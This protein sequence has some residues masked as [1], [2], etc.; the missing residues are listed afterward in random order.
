MTS[1]TLISEM[2]IHTGG[3]STEVTQH[4]D[5]AKRDKAIREKQNDECSADTD[6]ESGGFPI[7]NKPRWWQ[8]SKVSRWLRSI[9]KNNKQ[10]F[11]IVFAVFSVLLVPRT[12]FLTPYSTWFALINAL[13]D[14]LG[15][16]IPDNGL[17][18][19]VQNWHRPGDI[20]TLSSWPKDFSRDVIPVPCHSH[21]DYSR[22]VPLFDALAAG[23]VSVE[24]D[25]WSRNGSDDLLIGHNERSLSS[26]RTLKSLYIEPLMAILKHQNQG[27]AAT[28]VAGVFET[29]PN[30]TLVLLLD[31]KT[32]DAQ[33][34]T[35]M[36]K[37]LQPLRENGWLTRWN[38]TTGSRESG[39]VT[40]VASGDYPFD[41]ITASATQDV[42]ADA[43]L[44]GLDQRYTAKNSYYASVSM[45]KA[46]G[47]VHHGLSVE[48]LQVV[49]KQVKAALERG[50]VSR[51]WGTPSWPMSLRN[52]V[53]ETLVDRGV[54]VLNVDSLD[55]ATRWDWRW[56]TVAGLKLCG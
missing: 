45:G 56:C 34:W 30:T 15:P 54:G 20:Q 8:R 28:E 35:M 25:I 51:Y 43:P 18:K 40:V 41:M 23:C 44:D 3:S 31:F 32:K 6:S 42:F 29:A 19:I 46:I 5:G 36:Q 33:T 2:P 27:R 49:D 21:N 37:Q 26:G 16:R 12:P 14:R 55:T 24:G 48:Q 38:S 17:Q 11:W 9:L 1:Y 13:I 10:V 7:G 39:P 4:T 53:W 52:R 50:L 47:K 22:K